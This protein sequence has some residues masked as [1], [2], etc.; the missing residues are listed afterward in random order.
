M[1]SET[2]EAHIPVT[3]EKDYGESNSLPKLK[4]RYTKSFPFKVIAI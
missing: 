2:D 3:N 1:I 4:T